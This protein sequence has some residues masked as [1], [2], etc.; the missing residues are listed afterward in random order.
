[1]IF[2]RSGDAFP[3]FLFLRPFATL[4]GAFELTNSHAVPSSLP[5]EVRLVRASRTSRA[6]CGA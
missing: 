1:V 4:A 5:S 3:L 6:G 2:A